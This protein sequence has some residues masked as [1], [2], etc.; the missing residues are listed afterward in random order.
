[1]EIDTTK[2]NAG[3][4]YDY[5]L[6]GSHNFEVDR[7]AAEQLL[8]LIPSAK[9]GARLNRWFLY[10]VVERLALHRASLPT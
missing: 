7:R 9:P 2:P 8:A 10:D 4:I 1:M 3:R 5:Y 6:G